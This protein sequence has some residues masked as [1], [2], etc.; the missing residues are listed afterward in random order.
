M[1]RILRVYS[2]CYK[3]GTALRRFLNIFIKWF[4]LELNPKCNFLYDFVVEHHDFTHCATVSVII[5]GNKIAFRFL[6][7]HMFS[8]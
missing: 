1:G 8:E 7:H 3:F 2:L 4:Y 6:R 5:Y